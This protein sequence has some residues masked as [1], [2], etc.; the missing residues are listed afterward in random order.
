MRIGSA[1]KLGI[2]AGSWWRPGGAPRIGALLVFALAGLF[3]TAASAVSTFGECTFAIEEFIGGDAE[4]TYSLELIEGGYL[5]DGTDDI[6]LTADV[7]LGS[8]DLRALYFDLADDSLLSGI[9]ISVISA[10]GADLSGLSP[11]INVGSG[12]NLLGGNPKVYFDVGIEVGTPGRR[13]FIDEITLVIMHDSLDLDLSVF[14]EQLFGARTTSKGRKLRGL[15]PVIVPEPA[16]AGLTL[17][18]LTM[19]AVAG[20]RRS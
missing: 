19:L 14:S 5:G 8:D 12:A 6:L 1:S 15:A 20:R 13:D 3:A 18:G 9:S 11:V 4:V 17:L 2:A 16:T 7:T 10:G